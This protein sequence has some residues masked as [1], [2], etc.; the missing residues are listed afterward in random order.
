MPDI[1]MCSNHA[2]PL[3]ETCYRYMAEP[4]PWRQSY[5]LFEP[6]NGECEHLLPLRPRRERP[7]TS[8]GPS[9]T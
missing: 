8:T 6:K 4:N 7:I 3:R 1:T 2:C 5:S 9:D